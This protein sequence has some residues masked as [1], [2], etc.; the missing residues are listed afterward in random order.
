MDPK[1][2]DAGLGIVEVLVGPQHALEHLGDVSKVEEVVDLGG[3]G[4]EALRHSAVH[5]QGGLGHHVPN[6]LHLFLKV[7]ELLVDHGAEYPD[8][9]GL[10]GEG[11]VDDIKSTLQPWGD[12]GPSTPRRAHG[13]H[14]EH[15]SNV[16]DG[17]LRSIIPEAI[18]NPEANQLQRGLGPK[19]VLGWHIEVIHEGDHAFASERHID[20]LG[21][22]LHPA[23]ND[24][25][26]IIRRG[27]R[28]HVDCEH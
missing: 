13:S 8:D 26:H 11:H 21:S 10:R 4:Q 25:L 12:D 5:V 17:L 18:V 16:L 24:A 27:L 2:G 23:L 28:R 15:V 19:R 14:Q 3:G 6:G 7:L 9:L 20:T 22:L 1:S